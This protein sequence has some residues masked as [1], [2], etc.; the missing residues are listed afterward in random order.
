MIRSRHSIRAFI[1]LL[2][3]MI[4][5]M[6]VGGAHLHLCMDGSEPPVSVHVS[7]DAGLERGSTGMDQVHHDQYVSLTGEVLAKGWSRA[8][9]A[10]T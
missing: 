2:C 5:V 7:A 8:K 1:T 4:L 6:R 9:S 3:I 10:A